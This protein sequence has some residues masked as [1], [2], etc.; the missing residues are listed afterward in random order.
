MQQRTTVQIDLWL[1]IHLSYHVHFSS[2][3][4]TTTAIGPAGFGLH[5]AHTLYAT[6]NRLQ[7]RLISGLICTCQARCISVQRQA[8][9]GDARK[10]LLSLK[11]SY[12]RNCIRVDAFLPRNELPR[13]PFPCAHCWC[14]LQAI[15]NCAH[16]R[17]IALWR[18]PK[19]VP[20][21]RPGM[22]RSCKSSIAVQ[23]LC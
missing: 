15:T 3:P 22:T 4:G 16:C 19:D 5:I 10:C 2:A 11:S 12:Q 6:E 21:S 17:K 8:S 7:C 1:G 14:V 23:W 20:G 9:C 18:F 13:M